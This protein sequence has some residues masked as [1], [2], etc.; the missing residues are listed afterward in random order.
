MI[1][2]VPATQD[3]ARRSERGECM[4][5]AVRWDRQGTL[6]TLQSA[7]STSRTPCMA[8]ACT[9]GSPQPSDVIRAR[10]DPGPGH[11]D[12][13]S[14]PLAQAERGRGTS[15]HSWEQ[16]M[17]REGSSSGRETE[18]CLRGCGLGRDFVGQ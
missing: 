10:Q 11:T 7:L 3:C 15:R 2:A 18:D 6:C 8:C 9:S 12:E 17:L 16:W 1:P 5:Q 14:R 13:P 4:A